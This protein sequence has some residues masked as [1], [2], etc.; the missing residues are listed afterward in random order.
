MSFDREDAR[1]LHERK[2]AEKVKEQLGDMGRLQH[3]AILSEYVMAQPEWNFYLTQLQAELNVIRTSIESLTRQVT[4]EEVSDPNEISRMKA[5]LSRYRGR[6]EAIE[7]AIAL[8]SKIVELG[9]RATL[10]LENVDGQAAA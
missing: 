5:W 9:A 7:A 2:T 1:Q 8:P 10:A 6:A 4:S 3:A